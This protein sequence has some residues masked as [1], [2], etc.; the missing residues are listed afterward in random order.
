MWLC[1]RRGRYQWNLPKEGVRRPIL[2][3]GAGLE[4]R[5]SQPATVAST[6]S[7]PPA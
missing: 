7:G 3:T 5:N 6:D 2:D 4:L 1:M